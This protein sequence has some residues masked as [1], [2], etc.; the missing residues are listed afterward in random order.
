MNVEF[1]K[2]FEKWLSVINN[3]TVLKKVE[4]LILDLESAQSLDQIPKVKKL[5]GFSS[6]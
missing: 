3:K 2:S 1:D 5:S 4:K 6:Y